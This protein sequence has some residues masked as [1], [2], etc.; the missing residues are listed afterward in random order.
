V[1]YED[2]VE[3][4][5]LDSQLEFFCV[6]PLLYLHNTLITTNFD[7]LKYIKKDI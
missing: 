2:T 3:E 1:Y 6:V 7:V 5:N 4:Q